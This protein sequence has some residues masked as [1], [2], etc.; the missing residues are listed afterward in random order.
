MSV[1]SHHNIFIEHRANGSEYLITGKL[2]VTISDRSRYGI[3]P[4]YN[5]CYD[6]SYIE[7]L[8]VSEEDPPVEV[9][10]KEFEELIIESI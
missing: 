7:A 5:H 9:D 8:K 6:F 4:E 2:Y 1:H 3:E 10:V